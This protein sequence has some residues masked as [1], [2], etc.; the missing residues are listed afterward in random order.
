MSL[1]TLDSR[2]KLDSAFSTVP[3]GSVENTESSLNVVANARQS[4]LQIYFRGM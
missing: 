1:Q 4:N 3:G 2:I